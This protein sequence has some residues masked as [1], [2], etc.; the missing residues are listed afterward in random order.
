MRSADIAGRGAAG[1]ATKEG[2]C[3]ATESAQPKVKTTNKINTHRWFSQCSEYQNRRGGFADPSH[4]NK[5]LGAHKGNSSPQIN[6]GDRKD[7]TKRALFRLEPE[8][9]TGA[10]SLRGESR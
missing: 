1:V 6:V 9:K 2:L 10:R 8:G 4:S 7:V 5:V 3:K